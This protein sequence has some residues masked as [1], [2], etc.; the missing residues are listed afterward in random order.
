MKSIVD[1]TLFA[2]ALALAVPF[3]HAVPITYT[4]QLSGPAEE[5]T[6]DSPG[7]GSAT[8]IFDAEADSM[9]V[10]ANFSGLTTPTI[11]AHIH[12]CTAEPGEGTA[13]VATQT[14]SFVGFPLGV[15]SGTFDQT[16]ELDIAATW[17]QVFIDAQGSVAGAED[18]LAQGLASGT[19]YFNIHSVD[20]PGGE[21]RGFLQ[22]Q[23]VAVPEPAPLALLGLVLACFGLYRRSGPG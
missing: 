15:T 17:N 21:I 23:Q 19:S 11:A 12:C 7:T 18:A 16:F 13:G 22:E 6:N 20:F 8:V 2:V 5:P 9:R 14:P 1:R 3:A 10:T 4:A